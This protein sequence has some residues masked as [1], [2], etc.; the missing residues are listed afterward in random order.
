MKNSR[1]NSGFPA[2]R[3]G[4]P[5]PLLDYFVQ[6]YPPGTQGNYNSFSSKNP[7]TEK[8]KERRRGGRG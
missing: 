4:T 1:K 3:A 7:I 2:E 5:V 8:G 6:Q